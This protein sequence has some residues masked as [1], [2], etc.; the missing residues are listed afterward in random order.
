MGKS[1]GEFQR[2][3]SGSK[4]NVYNCKLFYAGSVISGLVPLHG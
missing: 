2:Q 1:T 3:K 4:R